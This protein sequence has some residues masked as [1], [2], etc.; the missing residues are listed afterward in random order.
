MKVIRSAYGSE[1]SHTV[2]ASEAIAKWKEWNMKC[3]SPLFVNC[4]WNRMNGSG[5]IAEA[6]VATQRTMETDGLGNSQYRIS[7]FSERQRAIQDGWPPSKYDPFNRLGRGLAVDGVLDTLAGFVYADA[8]CAF[9]LRKIK[10][11]GAKVILDR[12]TGKFESLLFAPAY[13]KVRKKN[14]RAI[15]IKTSDGKEHISDI[16]IMAAGAQTHELVPGLERILNATGANIVHV[17]VPAE[18][19]EK[20]R[21]DVFPVFSWN[22]TGYDE[23][24]GLSGFPIDGK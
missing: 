10:Q 1:S 9:A 24:G 18:L 23:D 12:V 21:S 22:Y 8:A 14:K 2:L 13:D 3:G 20:F 6:E 4:G 11:L 19:Q 17:K 16:V 7:N 5:K 15:G